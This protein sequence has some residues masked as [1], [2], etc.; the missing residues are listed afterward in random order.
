MGNTKLIKNVH[1]KLTY[2]N[3]KNIGEATVRID[4]IGDFKGKIIKTFKII[5]K[6]N[7]DENKE[8][9]ITSVYS[10]GRAI[11]AKN[12]NLKADNS[13]VINTLNCSDSQKFKFIK[14]SDE[15]YYIQNMEMQINL[16]EY[17]A[18]KNSTRA[19]NANSVSTNT[20]E[21]LGQKWYIGQN[22]DNTISFYTSDGL[23]IDLTGDKNNSNI[24]TNNVNNN[25]SQKFNLK[26]S[27]EISSINIDTNKYYYIL[28]SI[29]TKKAIDVYG[30]RTDNFTNVDI[31][32]LNKTN[33]QK[34]RFEK[35]SDGS[36][37]IL[38]KA[39]NKALDV[40]ANKTANMTNVDIYTSNKTNA[41]KW[42]ILKNSDG[43][44]TFLS[45]ESG[46]ALDLYAAS[47]RNFNNIE[48]WDWNQ[49]NAQKWK[50]MQE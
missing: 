19:V 3:N 29:N 34:F 23:V 10:K 20:K 30:G 16:K 2:Y 6:P 26:S 12:G 43:T 9:F 50:L 41:Q 7:I 1:Y 39:S 4:G 47:V 28:S 25:S 37:T 31:Y 42:F 24:K 14:N 45:A 44:I 49:T 11:D 36:Y 13:T 38:N 48:I 40:Y 35:N 17:S 21:D 46:K 32:D 18:L 15:S 8:Y 27:S 22:S 5:R 33:A